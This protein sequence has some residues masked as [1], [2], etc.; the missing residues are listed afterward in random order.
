MLSEL[1]DT[2]AVFQSVLVSDG[3]L[4]GQ[5]LKHFVPD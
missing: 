4:V 1:Q 3:L 5:L 2:V